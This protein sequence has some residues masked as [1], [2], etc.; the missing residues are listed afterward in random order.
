MK[1]EP[2]T[3]AR[4]A[5]SAGTGRR[6]PRRAAAR[7]SSDKSA[8]PKHRIMLV[9]DHPVLRRGLAQIINRHPALLVCGEADQASSALAMVEE[10]RPD[11]VVVDLSIKAGDGLELI[12]AIKA[13]HPKVFLL[14]LS[15]HDE[16]LYAERALR[17][18]AHGYIMK[19]EPSELVLSAIQ[20]VID[21]DVFLSDRMKR[22][23]LEDFV[24]GPRRIEG[25]S[26]RDLSD[27]ELEVLRLVGNGFGTRQI[28]NRLHLSVKTI[29]SYREN[30][31]H[32]LR[33]RSGSELVQQ[34]IQWTKKENLMM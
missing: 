10:S 22:R 19:E 13:Q 17:A 6:S 18:G 33:V 16:N 2:K 15:M 5:Q 32:K 30:L 34:A 3:K 31:K 20:A 21:G 4:R 8:N 25:L 27:R 14:V 26:L 29:E 23:M 12:K 28:A 9:D 7:H 1:V 11:L 24:E